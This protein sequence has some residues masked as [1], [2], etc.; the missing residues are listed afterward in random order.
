[1]AQPSDSVDLSMD[2][3]LMGEPFVTR[4]PGASY[5]LL[6]MDAVWQGEPFVTW[7]PDSIV[8]PAPGGNFQRARIISFM[9]GV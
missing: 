3:V 4:I 2:Q 8:P 5:D 6:G 9:W 1:M 7:N